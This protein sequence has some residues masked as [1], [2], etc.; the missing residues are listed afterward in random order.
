MKTRAPIK[1]LT[2]FVLVAIWTSAAELRAANPRV[3]EQVT[4]SSHIASIIFDNCSGCHRPGQSGPFSLLT[5]E[6]VRRHSETIADV[7]QHRYMPPWKPS[8]TG[9]A[10]ANHRSLSQDQIDAIASWLAADCPQGDP[11]SQPAPRQYDDA[12]ALGTPDLIL[13]MDKPFRVPAD[14]PDIYRS[15]VLPIQLPEDRWI[16]AIEMRPQSRGVVH[17]ALFFVDESGLARKQ[18]ERDDQPGLRGMNFLRGS[19]ANF[20]QRPDRLARSLGGYVPGATPNRLPGDLARPLP[21][22]SDIIV[23]THFHPTGKEEVEQSELGLYFAAKPTQQLIVPI[24]LPPLFGIG[25][26]IDIPAGEDN[27][28]IS[29]SYVLPIDVLGIEVGGH[30]HYICKSMLMTAEL[31]SGKALKLLQIDDWDLDWQDQYQFAEMIELPQGTKL[32][33]RIAYDNSAANPENPFSPPKRIQWG[34]EST[35]E[36]GSITLQVIAK[37]EGEREELEQGVRQ[38]MLSSIRSRVASQSGA[39]GQLVRGRRGGGGLLQLLDRDQ[40]GILAEDE[41]PAQFRERLMDMFDVDGDQKLD[42]TEIR[43]AQESIEGLTRETDR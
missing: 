9:I 20:L 23:Q 1:K 28:E 17:H 27:H 40:D 32:T 10:Y 42:A 12:W 33:V 38:Q 26:G 34:R 3:D 11:A 8:D 41:I 43:N 29:H 4:F 35:D 16:K 31:P 39:L 13:K 19:G 7:T 6:E 30:A 5:F 14:G 25:A 24:Q 18:K 22:G 37:N 36:M 2:F 21:A 15:F